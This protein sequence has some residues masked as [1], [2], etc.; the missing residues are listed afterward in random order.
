MQANHLYITT[1]SR[2]EATLYGGLPGLIKHV[3]NRSE[4]PET[5]SQRQQGLGLV[6]SITWHCHGYLQPMQ[7]HGVLSVK[8]LSSLCRQELFG[9]QLKKHR[10]RTWWHSQENEVVQ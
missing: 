5:L 10:S 3:G 7:Y 6:A 2:T 8:D 9:T 1:E 4:H